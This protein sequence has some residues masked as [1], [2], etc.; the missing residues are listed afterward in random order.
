[1]VDDDV[2]VVVYTARSVILVLTYTQ[3]CGR[4]RSAAGVSHRGASHD[5]AA[6]AARQAQAEAAELRRQHYLE[7]SEE[8]AHCHI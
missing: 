6:L 5:P 4:W 1:M 8:C 3:A 2:A 7:V